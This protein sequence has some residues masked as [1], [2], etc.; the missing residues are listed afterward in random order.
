MLRR[1]HHILILVENLSV[2]FDRRVWHESTTL[3]KAGYE[4]SVICPR[5]RR[6]DHDAFEERDGVH[7]Y[8]YPP[9][10]SA[11]SLA[12][13]PREYGHMLTWTLRLALR[14]YRRRPFDAIHACSPP[15]L[16]F[17]IGAFFRR[18]G[19]SFVYD[20]HDAS[21]EILRAKRGA[22]DHD[23]LPERVVAWAERRTFRLADV[24]ISPNDS[25]RHLALT[26]G[27]LAPEDV[28]VVRSAPRLDEFPAAAAAGFDRRGHRY[29]LGYLGVMGKQDGVDVLV[30]A[31]G[32]L[33][34]QGYDIL[35]YL[36][37]DGESYP[38]ICDLVRRSGI[39]DR[40]LMPGYQNNAEFTPALLAADVCV[41]P[42]PPGPF[43]DISTMNKLVEYM[44]LGR[45]AVAFGL[46]ENRFTGGD[47]V[48]YADEPTPE[49]L[50]EA[51]AGL[52]A[53]EE[54]RR[55]LGAAARRRFV[56][57]LAW[58]RSEAGLLQAYMRLGDKVANGGAAHAK[59]EN[60]A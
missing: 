27:Q 7:I 35:L 30:L 16:F 32:K 5:G 52:L 12:G 53:D 22:T 4:V 31:A 55:Q 14:L 39:E 17:L 25:Y 57:E 41:A 3:V 43:N 26:R 9:P 42:D 50:A 46:P 18:R 13:Y 21:P 48:A 29:L 28:F 10:P 38:G 51:I 47:A 33:V 54:R 1:P 19:V 36:A 8:R 24:V 44:A 59:P 11:S 58:E 2:P 6:H 37:G 15:D 40:V 49:G 20:Q 23:G 60:G 56:D 34:Q 45:P